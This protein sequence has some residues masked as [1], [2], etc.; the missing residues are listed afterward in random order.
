MRPGSLRVAVLSVVLVWTVGVCSASPQQPS[1]QAEDPSFERAMSLWQSGLYEGANAEF[2]NLV[3]R[4]QTN[5]DFKVQWGRLFLETHNGREAAA[6]FQEALAV[7][8]D[9]AGALLGLA[10]IATELGSRLEKGKWLCVRT[11][12]TSPQG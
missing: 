8:A 1:P 4:A 5:P 2:K 6:L 3:N 11:R 12:R 9:H 10:L 7:K